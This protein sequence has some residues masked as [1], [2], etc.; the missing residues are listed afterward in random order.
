MQKF[1]NSY[2]VLIKKLYKINYKETFLKN[3]HMV[4]LN[5]KYNSII[6]FPSSFNPMDPVPNY[7]F[8][9]IRK[10]LIENG[11]LNKKKFNKIFE[12]K[13]GRY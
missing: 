12:K 4:L 9:A 5:K 13:F 2:R 10:N 1:K 11:I 6:V 3:K 7:F 8:L